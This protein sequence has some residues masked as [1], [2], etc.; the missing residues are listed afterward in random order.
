MEISKNNGTDTAKIQEKAPPQVEK[1]QAEE[2]SLKRD[3]VEEG[4]NEDDVANWWKNAAYKKGGSMDLSEKFRQALWVYARDNPEIPWLDVV[5][6]LYFIYHHNIFKFCISF[7]GNEKDAEDVVQD[8]ISEFCKKERRNSKKGEPIEEII[9][10]LI[11]AANNK[12]NKIINEK[13]KKS[14]LIDGL[15]EEKSDGNYKINENLNRLLPYEE[16]E[17]VKNL[18][19]Q[20]NRIKLFK[21]FILQ[22][23]MNETRRKCVYKYFFIKDIT[24]EQIAWFE[25]ITLKAV[26]AH[27]NSFRKDHEKQIH[28]ILS[29]DIENIKDLL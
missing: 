6:G 19:P 4:W 3:K 2:S 24:L 10:Y 18:I 28:L 15:I 13:G 17:Q 21:Q 14:E 25:D 7:L 23:R 29:K 8:V 27:I 12:C 16:S 5:V 26:S 20:N 11:R 9:K 22:K 1:Q